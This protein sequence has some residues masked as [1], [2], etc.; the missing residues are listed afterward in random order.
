MSKINVNE[1]EAKTANSNLTLIPDGSGIL[2]IGGDTSGTLQL[3][4]ASGKNVKIQAPANSSA[5]NYTLT[6][7]TTAATQDQYL[8]VDSISGSGSTAVGQLGYV[9]VT[10]PNA[11]NIP[12]DQITSGIMPT[13]RY[14]VASLGG[15]YGLV[16]TTILTAGNNVTN[17]IFNN[18]D[19][20]STYKI[21]CPAMELQTDARILVDFLDQNDAQQQSINQ[22]YFSNYT[23]S[24]NYQNNT[25]KTIFNPDNVHY[26]FGFE[27]TICTGDPN[28]GS[29]NAKR[30]WM[31]VVGQIRSDRLMFNS[32]SS[33]TYNSGGN[34]Q[35]IHG[36]KFRHQYGNNIQGGGTE[37]YLYK[38]NEG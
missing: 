30:A 22:T 16:S 25:D 27:A 38:Y 7:P 19:A 36:V 18:L 29:N 34:T 11:N 4:N 23:Y 24:N 14:S 21:I 17:I 31:H 12:A 5:Q 37:L 10:P 35:R 32:W 8:Q 9:A 28:A 15:G 1:L 2:N 6:L 26:H 20:N 33:F 13:D 3:T